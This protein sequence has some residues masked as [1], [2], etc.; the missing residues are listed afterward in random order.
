MMAGSV[1]TVVSVDFNT[2]KRLLVA[3]HLPA[4]NDWAEAE[5]RAEQDLQCLR[6]RGRYERTDVEVSI[7]VLCRIADA[8]QSA[9]AG[10]NIEVGPWVRQVN[11]DLAD[12][13]LLC[14]TS[15]PRQTEAPG[16]R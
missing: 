11:T 16:R 14:R 7:Q 5:A 10:S 13:V 2:L 9:L 8:A 4:C 15:S 6:P 12:V 1:S 3:A